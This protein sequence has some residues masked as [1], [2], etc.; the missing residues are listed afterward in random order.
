MNNW[1]ACKVK[2]V[3]IDDRGKENKVTEAYL[4]DAMTYTEAEARLNKNLE[5]IISGEF[6][7][8]SISNVNYSD[9]F[10][11]D[12]GDRWYKCKVTYIDIDESAGKEKKSTKQMLVLA[13]TIKDAIDKLEESLS[14]MIVPYEIL[15]VQDSN[16]FDIFPYKPSE[17]VENIENNN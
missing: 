11:F 7:L 14:T 3:K 15:A 2:Y 5:E 17:S 13:S 9:V 6:T 12:D 10:P 8:I 16:I 1:F 4:V